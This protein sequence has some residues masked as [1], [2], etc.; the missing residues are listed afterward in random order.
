MKFVF[1]IV[2]KNLELFLKVVVVYVGL[3]FLDFI[4]F[5]FYWDVD[6]FVKFFNFRVSIFCLI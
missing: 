1:V 4:N 2:E 3:E 6:E 5:F